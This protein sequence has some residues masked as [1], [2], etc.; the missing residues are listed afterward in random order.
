MGYAGSDVIKKILLVAGRIV[1]R[2]IHADTLDGRDT[3]SVDSRANAAPSLLLSLDFHTI[4]LNIH[5]HSFQMYPRSLGD[6]DR[7]GL[8]RYLRWGGYRIPLPFEP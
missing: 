5:T 8:V 7:P 1:D 6:G 4:G 3:I 2:A